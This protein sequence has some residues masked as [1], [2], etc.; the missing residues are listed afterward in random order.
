M[1][2]DG[3]S[4]SKR[5]EQGG[6][7]E[8]KQENVMKGAGELGLDPVADSREDKLTPSL[9]CARSPPHPP[10]AALERTGGSLQIYVT[11][12]FFLHHAQNQQPPSLYMHACICILGGCLFVFEIRSLYVALAVLE[13]T[14]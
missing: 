5:M 4:I 12:L 3:G 1:S 8:M 2:K 13:H 14:I 11:V 10:T 6:Q 7:E 9:D